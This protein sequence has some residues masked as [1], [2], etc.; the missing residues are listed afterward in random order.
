MSQDLKLST[1]S[2]SYEQQMT[3]QSGAKPKSGCGCF[4][5][6]CFGLLLLILVP[7]VGSIVYI[8][9]LDGS[10]A[11]QWI[12]QLATHEEFRKEFRNGINNNTELTQEQ[13]TMLLGMYEK[14]LTNY[15]SMSNDEKQSL[16]RSIYDLTVKIITDGDNLKGSAPPQEFL[17]ILKLL[18][19]DNELM[20]LQ[21]QLGSSTTTP[22]QTTPPTT[23]TTTTTNDPYSFDAGSNQNTTTP[24]S[25][26]TTTPTQPST[27]TGYKTEYDF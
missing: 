12:A 3:D 23:T 16:H 6:G 25:T 20:L 21:S 7:F 4:V 27:G 26:T 24:T 11:G 1:A 15:D 22:T 13:R 5:A 8:A 9:S 19:M 2:T 14:F 10:D 17:D 18:K